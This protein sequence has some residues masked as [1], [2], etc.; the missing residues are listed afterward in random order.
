MPSRYNP[1]PPALFQWDE[2]LFA[3]FCGQKQGDSKVIFLI[4]DINTKDAVKEV[5]V[6]VPESFA[7]CKF[8]V[9][10]VNRNTLHIFLFGGLYQEEDRAYG[11]C[12]LLLYEYKA[13][14]KRN[15][16]CKII[17]EGPESF[18]GSGCCVTLLP[19][20]VARK[21]ETESK[22]IISWLH[23]N[24]STTLPVEPRIYY[25]S[26]DTGQ[27][28][29]IEATDC[30]N[31]SLYCDRTDLILT[32][33]CRSKGVSTINRR[34]LSASGND[35][36]ST[37]LYTSYTPHN[38]IALLD[39]DNEYVAFEEAGD[40]CVLYVEKRLLVKLLGI[41]GVFGIRLTRNK[42]NRYLVFIDSP[43][44]E[45]VGLH[46]RKI[47]PGGVNAEEQF[48]PLEVANELFNADYLI[49][50]GN[51][52]IIFDQTTPDQRTRRFYCKRARLGG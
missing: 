30:I 12:V 42:G 13:F 11:R 8:L 32:T 17:W 9:L 22:Y 45:R 35:P 52:T 25:Y 47:Y 10:P 23:W 43:R 6:S 44:K 33:L 14:E 18:Y 2:K 38:L 49:E 7:I 31:F 34:K 29:D 50:D 26:S 37:T 51:I 16:S 21:Y 48:I 5:V 4:H 3:V 1:Q 20:V 46:V 28:Y 36:D 24:Y 41:S 15:S 27:I 40:P 39:S 19:N